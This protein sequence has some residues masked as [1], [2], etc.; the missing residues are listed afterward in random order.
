MH[1]IRLTQVHTSLQPSLP[2]YLTDTKLNDP[3]SHFS[4][5]I[6]INSFPVNN[7]REEELVLL[8]VVVFCFVCLFVVYGGPI[9]VVC[10]VYDHDVS[11]NFV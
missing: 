4:V 11:I 5:E 2:C 8:L 6:Q 7:C 1:T 10:W 9:P 3:K